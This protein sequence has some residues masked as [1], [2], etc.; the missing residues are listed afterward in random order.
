M[1][2][3]LSGFKAEGRSGAS[4][5]GATHYFTWSR[6]FEVREEISGLGQ[7][8]AG[9]R[10]LSLHLHF[11]EG[12]DH[13]ARRRLSEGGRRLERSEDEHILQ[14]RKNGLRLFRG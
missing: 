9:R 1:S 8:C 7:A 3:Q 10:N 4:L 2:A 6:L 12:E 14:L 5:A 13:T 11:G